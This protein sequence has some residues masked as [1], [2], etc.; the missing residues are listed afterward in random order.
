MYS[1][2]FSSIILKNLSLNIPGKFTYYIKML[3]KNKF[4]VNKC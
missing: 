2:L 3:G 1:S 4:I